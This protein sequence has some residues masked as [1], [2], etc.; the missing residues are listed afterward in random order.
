M[1]HLNLG[2]A[3]WYTGLPPSR[4]HHLAIF[5]RTSRL[6]HEIHHGDTEDT[7]KNGVETGGRVAKW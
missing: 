6:P 1:R 4:S 7:E 2:E 3:A 5:M